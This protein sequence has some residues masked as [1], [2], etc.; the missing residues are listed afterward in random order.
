MDIV[1]SRPLYLPPSAALIHVEIFPPAIPL[2]CTTVSESVPLISRMDSR[3][4][5]WRQ[6]GDARCVFLECYG[7]MT[8]NVLLAVDAQEFHHPEWVRALLHRF[9][10][11]YFLALDAYDAGDDATPLVWHYTFR[12]TTQH[13]L[14]VVQQLFL[15]VNAHINYDL[16]LTLIDMLDSSWHALTP[17]EREAFYA[18]HCHINEVIERTIDAVQDTVVERCSPSMDLIDTLLGRV[19]EFMIGQ[20]IRRWRG[21]V[22]ERAE[23]LLNAAD[24][25]QRDA[26][27]LELQHDVMHTARRIS[28]GAS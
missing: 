18:D 7:L 16:V 23:A 3:I 22:W 12:T 27:L 28:L 20:L 11:Y 4:A 26:L 25:A 21:A 19:D 17:Q 6:C 10:D 15:G 2:L 13:R 8:R 9:A 1:H 5:T 24:A 14:H